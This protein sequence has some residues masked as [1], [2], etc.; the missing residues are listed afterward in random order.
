MLRR[1]ASA[2]AV[3]GAAGVLV[4]C[5]L[6]VSLD[7]LSGD[8]DVKADDAAADSTFGDGTVDGSRDAS[9]DRDAG[10]DARF[11]DCPGTALPVPVRLAAGFCIDSTEV[12]NAQ[13]AA[14]LAARGTDV[15]GQPVTCAGNA[16]FTPRANW[17]PLAGR[18][19]RPVVYVDW[20]DAYAY[21][22]WA[23]KRLCGK[24]GTGL[25]IT[26]AEG[27]DPQVDEWMFACTTGGTLNYPYGNAFD[28]TRCNGAAYDAG[29]PTDVGSLPGC[30]GGF[31]G[32]F[33]MSGNV[34]EWE[35]SCTGGDCSAR[36]GAFD[37][38][39]STGRL[40]CSGRSMVMLGNSYSAD[41]FRCC[42]TP[43]DD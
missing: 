8:R 13:Y 38:D 15:S 41:G 10:T 40:A 25:A 12:T 19:A 39:V 31:P 22:A 23:G 36:G 30:V 37:V 2:V 20:C 18:D 26:G 21:C 29:S 1:T 28:A 27:L 33:D 24:I 5:S 32:L 14:F 6:L 17:P 16:T 34:Y 42:G 4:H 11:A 7:G 35:N 3:L 43:R 9:S